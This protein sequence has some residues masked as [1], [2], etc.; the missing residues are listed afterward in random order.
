MLLK[1]ADSPRV[2][3]FVKRNG[4]SAGFAR[5]F[6]AGERMED[7]VRPVLA[8]NNQGI[9]ATLDYLGENVARKEDA[10]ESAA[11]YLKLLDFIEE[12]G[13]DSNVSLKLTQLGLDISD[14][15]AYRNLASIL[16]RATEYDQFVRIDM[17]GSAYTQR[18]LDIFYRLWKVFK[19]VGAVIQSYLHRSQE[20]VEKLIE[21]GARVRLVKGAYS[22]PEEVA[23]QQKSQVDRNFVALMRLLLDGGN[24]P[25][26]ATHDEA[27][28]QATRQYAREKEVPSD[29]FE[30]QMLY[31]IRR[32]RQTALARQ[33]Y[34]MRVYVPFGAHWYPYMMRRLAERPANLWFVA[35]NLL[36]R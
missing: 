1:L 11:Y 5:R 33:G 34:R 3:R 4:M 31:G 24:Y 32:E 6:I 36:K 21:A 30:F 23:L 28:I 12:Q 7:V 22:E 16:R 18:T 14:D 20:D 15:L 9:T 13:L 26:I 8:L 19:N 10:E 2:E 25:A 29:R 17:E 27:M 35:K